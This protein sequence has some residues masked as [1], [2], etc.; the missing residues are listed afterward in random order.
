MKASEAPSANTTTSPTSTLK[1]DIDASL[2]D[3]GGLYEL[4]KDQLE[5]LVAEVVREEGFAELVSIRSH[6]RPCTYY[7][8]QPIVPDELVGWHVEDQKPCRYRCELET[9]MMFDERLVRIAKHRTT[10]GEGND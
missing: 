4:S 5:R 9:T 6:P 3:S 2:R 10:L 8:D 1:S 7:A